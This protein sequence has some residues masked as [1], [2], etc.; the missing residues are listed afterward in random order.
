M[1]VDFGYAA[2]MTS[3]ERED[4]WLHGVRLT[5]RSVGQRP[6]RVRPPAFNDQSVEKL[7]FV[8]NRLTILAITAKMGCRGGSPW[9]P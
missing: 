2:T 4:I 1:I 7:G 5:R 9:K 6:Y 8:G 3:L